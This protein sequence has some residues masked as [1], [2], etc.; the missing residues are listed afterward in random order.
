MT[1]QGFPR[2]VKITP[3]LLRREFNV[4]PPF[5]AAGINVERLAPGRA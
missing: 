4:W 2:S 5:L 1:K 3:E